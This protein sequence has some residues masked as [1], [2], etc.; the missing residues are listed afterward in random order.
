MTL[1]RWRVIEEQIEIEAAE[2]DIEGGH[3]EISSGSDMPAAEEADELSPGQANG[4][5]EAGEGD[6]A[7]IA[8]VSEV[9]IEVPPG[10]IETPQEV[11][12]FLEGEGL[13]TE[14]GIVADQEVEAIEALESVFGSD[15]RVRV[16]N[17]RSYPW[18]T[19]CHLYIVSRTGRR[20]G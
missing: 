11:E 5:G 4:G 12:G 3:E 18:R 7:V 17:T 14:A 13:F 8:G 19:I 10:G 6:E 20:G 2:S 9:G 1:E 16:W 15:D